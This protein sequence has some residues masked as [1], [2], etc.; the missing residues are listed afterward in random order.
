MGQDSGIYCLC[1]E[2]F[3]GLVCNETEKG[4]CSQWPAS[5]GS[6]QVGSSCS[7]RNSQPLGKASDFSMRANQSFQRPSWVQDDGGREEKRLIWMDRLRLGSVLLFA[8]FEALSDYLS[9]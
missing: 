7:S 2:G 4:T 5:P 1:P 3:T 9:I 6:S 8:V